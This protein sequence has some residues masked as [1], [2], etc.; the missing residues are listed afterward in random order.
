VE[1]DEEDG[2]VAEDGDGSPENAEIV[3]DLGGDDG[4][5]AEEVGGVEALMAAGAYPRGG[6]VSHRWASARDLV[7]SPGSL[8]GGLPVNPGGRL[9]V[10][11]PGLGLGTRGGP[12]HHARIGAEVIRSRV[13]LL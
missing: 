6:A 4:D 3:D 7:C 8:P 11:S 10:R 2:G 13:T 5:A 1:V 12:A 9:S